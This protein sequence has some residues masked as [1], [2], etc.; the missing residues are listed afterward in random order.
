MFIY[1]V[2][3]FFLEFVRGDEGR[4]VLFGT[5]MTDTQGIALAMVIAGTILWLR[6]V[7]L[8][9]PAVATAR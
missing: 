4:G 7:P 9:A 6:R 1:G 8:R 3:R 5:W 2:A